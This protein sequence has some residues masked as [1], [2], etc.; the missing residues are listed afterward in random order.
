MYRRRTYRRNPYRRRYRRRYNR[1]KVGYKRR[2]RTHYKG[3]SGKFIQ[4]K[5]SRLQSGFPDTLY[6]KLKYFEASYNWNL[7]AGTLL[8]SYAMKC[9]S[10]RDPYAPTGGK[11]ALY[12]QTYMN[13][14]EYC[15]VQAVKITMTVSRLSDVNDGLVLAMVPRTTG[16]A[17]YV[18]LDDIISQ[19][20]VRYTTKNPSRLGNNST[21]TWYIPIHTILKLTKLQYNSAPPG[22]SYDCQ[23]TSDPLFP[24]YISC[25]VAKLNE[26]VS[27]QAVNC[28]GS[29]KVVYYCKFHTRRILVEQGLGLVPESG[30]DVIDPDDLPDEEVEIVDE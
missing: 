27:S 21:L 26:T 6:T 3:S 16:D 30:I 5:F 9:N 18:D 28:W 24:A 1:R 23:L 11:S 14:Y 2:G 25:I 7:D 12:F 15:R 29:I 22:P 10:P 4:S 13:L 8:Q 20:R 19:P 17:V